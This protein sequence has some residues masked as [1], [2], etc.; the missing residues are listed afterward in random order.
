[1]V[2]ARLT[3]TAEPVHVVDPG[4]DTDDSLDRLVAGIGPGGYTGLRMGLVTA[5]VL[6]FSLGLEINEVPGPPIDRR[7]AGRCS[8]IV[9][10]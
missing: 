1:M 5:R 2:A 9:G 8:V 3:A 6:A 10:G 4:W 7:L